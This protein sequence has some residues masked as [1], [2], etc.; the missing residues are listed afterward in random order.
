V[1]DF[2][3]FKKK[4]QKLVGW[5]DISGMMSTILILFII[6][7]KQHVRGLWLRLRRLRGEG[8]GEGHGGCVASRRYKNI[9][10]CTGV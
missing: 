5:V 3:A 4:I 9:F 6:R 7:V 2:Y 8:E 10:F 1:V